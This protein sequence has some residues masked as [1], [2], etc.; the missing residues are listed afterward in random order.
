MV[1]QFRVPFGT[2]YSRA[3]EAVEINITNCHLSP[4]QIDP[5]VSETFLGW[6][7]ASFSFSQMISSLIMGYWSE[8]RNAKEPLFVS[9]VL[10]ACGGVLYAYAEAFGKNGTWIVLGGRILFGLSAGKN[11]EKAYE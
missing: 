5:S 8:K 10:V 1:F 6:V 11:N 7:N 9:T 2:A 4:I 3:V